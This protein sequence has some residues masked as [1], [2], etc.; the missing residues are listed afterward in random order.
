MPNYGY[1]KKTSC[2]KLMQIK[3]NWFSQQKILNIWYYIW[4]RQCIRSW[5]T[6]INDGY[7]GKNYNIEYLVIKWLRKCLK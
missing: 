1:N 4:Q 5:N 2:I 6:L 7:Q 3:R